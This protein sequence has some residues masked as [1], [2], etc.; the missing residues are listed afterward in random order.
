MGARLR[1]AAAREYCEGVGG[2]EWGVR[3]AVDQQ[4]YLPDLG[5]QSD[6]DAREDVVVRDGNERGP[7]WGGG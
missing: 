6:A 2:A 5:T 3:V 7:C 4:D 1:V